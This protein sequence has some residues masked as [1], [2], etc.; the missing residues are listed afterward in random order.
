M[1]YFEELNRKMA[2]L[3]GI[4]KGIESR[5]QQYSYLNSPVLS[6]IRKGIERFLSAI[7][8]ASVSVVSGIRKGI[9]RCLFLLLQVSED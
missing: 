3:A 6:G 9:E 2:D 7:N 4:R 8:L 5:L 1:S